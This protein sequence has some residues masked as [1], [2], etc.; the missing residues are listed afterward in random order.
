MKK[1]LEVLQYG[2]TDIRFNTDIDICQNPRIIE[3]IAGT[4]AVCML[5]KLSGGNEHSVL[6]VLRSLTI[7]DFATCVERKEL[8]ECLLDM[9]EK[10]ADCIEETMQDMKQKGTKVTTIPPDGCQSGVKS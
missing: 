10:L 8:A 5:T 1:L 9:S 4:A 7:A 6:A 2:E 3:E